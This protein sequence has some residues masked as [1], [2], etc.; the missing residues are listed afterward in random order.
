MNTICRNIVS[1]NVNNVIIPRSN[2]SE[3]DNVI[4][5]TFDRDHCYKQLLKIDCTEND[6]Y[7]N[8]LY[9]KNY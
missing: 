4:T 6:D 1:I 8:Q 3:K 5:C 9:E 2:F 7:T